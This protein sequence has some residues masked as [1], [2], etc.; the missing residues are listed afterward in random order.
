MTLLGVKVAQWIVPVFALSI[1]LP[2]L[3]DLGYSPFDLEFVTLGVFAFVIGGLFALLLKKNKSSLWLVNAIFVYII[4]DGFFFYNPVWPTILAFIIWIFHEKIEE[5]ELDF[6]LLIF[7]LFWLVSVF[8]IPSQTF[9]YH[10][11]QKADA[12][13]SNRPPIVHIILDEQMSPTSIKNTEFKNYRDTIVRG[14][15]KRGFTIFPNIVSNSTSTQISLS[16]MVGFD[17]TNLANNIL[18]GVEGFTHQVKRNLYFDALHDSGYKINVIQ[19]NYLDF[20]KHKYVSSCV[21]YSRATDGHEMTRFHEAIYPRIIVA[22]YELNNRFFETK[23]SVSG[24]AL[25]RLIIRFLKKLNVG[26]SHESVFFTRPA[27]VLNV[28]DNMSRTL[29]SIK[30]GNVYFAHLLMPHFPYVVDESCQL[31]ESD[32]W[33]VPNRH[34]YIKQDVNFIFERYWKQSECINQKLFGLIDI[35]MS[36][37]S[38]QQAIWIVHGDHGARLSKREL[39]LKAEFSVDDYFGTFLTI[40]ANQSSLNII[41]EKMSL[42]SNIHN[43]INSIVSQRNEVL[44]K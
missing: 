17:D 5:K 22:I 8:L 43:V 40:K 38:G 3:K 12:D 31:A 4:L 33:A 19:S 2:A 16:N 20:C 37:S 24:V 39:Q 35:V 30:P 18:H 41:S 26:P 14:Y 27:T 23:K 13:A 44:G 21:T 42:Q 11:A 28:V 25:Y 32:E 10:F 34:N 29:A 6:S 7:S 36:Q 1:F 15:E 9:S